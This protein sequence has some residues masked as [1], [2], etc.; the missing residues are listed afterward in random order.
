MRKNTSNNKYNQTHIS[1]DHKVLRFIKI[2]LI[3]LYRTPQ[4]MP[5]KSSGSD[6]Y[7]KTAT[8][9]TTSDKQR[10]KKNTIK[11]KNSKQYSTEKYSHADHFFR[12]EVVAVDT[13]K[14]N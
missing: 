5:S 4:D 12:N 2:G 1:G 13:R 3:F 10:E 14:E 6:Q 9:T 7:K 11:T 8:K